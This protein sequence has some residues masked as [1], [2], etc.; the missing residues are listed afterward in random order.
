M[1][2]FAFNCV[3]CSVTSGCTGQETWHS[4]CPNQSIRSVRLRDVEAFSGRV[5][6]RRQQ[7]CD[8]NDRDVQFRIGETSVGPDLGDSEVEKRRKEE[9]SSKG[10]MKKYNRTTGGG[11][12]GSVNRAHCGTLLALPR[13]EGRA[14]I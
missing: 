3:N 8:A 7:E 11:V 10:E 14:M 13:P 12:P 2:A 9:E 5:G 4:R 1:T 6:D